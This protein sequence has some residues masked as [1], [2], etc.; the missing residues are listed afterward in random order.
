MGGWGYTPKVGKVYV[1]ALTTSWA[2][3]LTA[4]Q[5]KATRGYMVKTRQ[6]FDV[7]G[8][9]SHAPCPFDLAFTSSPSSGADSDGTG[10][11]SFSGVGSGQVLGPSNGL[12]A[13]TSVAVGTVL[14]EII[15]FE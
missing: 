15:V 3:V 11:Y 14:L 13:R 5:A 10:F 8:S 6:S 9:P 2:Q 12:Y 1:V 4:A 7:D